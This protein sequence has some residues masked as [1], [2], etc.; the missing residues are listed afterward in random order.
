MSIS[1]ETVGLALAVIA[2]GAAGAALRYLIDSWTV[3][4]WGVG[5]PWGTWAVNVAGSFLIGAV[6]GTSLSVD[7]PHWVQLLLA[8]GFCGA[9][10]TFSAFALQVLDL[11]ESSA[12]AAAGLK[13]S[14][15]WRGVA[16]AVVSLAAG[17][18]AVWLVP[19]LTGSGLT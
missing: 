7:M 1:V 9:L 6:L 4:K 8:T 14:F 12:A 19:A 5:W 11:S 18:F 10:T 3:A 16:Y 15:A 2:G 17:M 13:G